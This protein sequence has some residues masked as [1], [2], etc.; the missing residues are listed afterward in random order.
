LAT[1]AKYTIEV[2][3]M[4]TVY[5]CEGKCKGVA[6]EEQ[7]R[8]GATKCAAA[9]CDLFQKPLQKRVKCEKCGK[10][11]MPADKHV[12]VGGKSCG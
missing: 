5:V 10:I 12:C 9:D 7:H 3:I 8:Q 6:T 11:E 1:E 4:K 2:L